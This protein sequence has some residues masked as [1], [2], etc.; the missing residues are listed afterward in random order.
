MYCGVDIGGT[1]VLMALFSEKGTLEK[2]I[3]FPT[4][5]KYPDLLSEL[6]KHSLELVENGD[7]FAAGIAI[8]GRIDRELGT[9]ISF[10]NLGWK[11][12]PIQRDVERILNCP[13]A[14]E[15]DA[16]AGAFSEALCILEDYKKVMYVAIGTGI[17]L[18]YVVDGVI[19]V[20]FGDR[21]GNQLLLPFQGKLQTWE[22]FASGKAIVNRYGKRAED[23]NDQRIWKRISQD[24]ASGIVELMAL[25]DIDAV[26][27]G[28]G[29]GKYFA[30]YGKL[31]NAAVKKYETPVMPA[32]VILP[33]K[34]PDE[35]VVYGGYE[36]A[37]RA[38][39]HPS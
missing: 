24:L 22:S 30:K 12:V 29:V 17:G 20:D 21:G 38:Y 11:N 9:G 10:G 15:N 1:K 18:G 5:K 35:A 13:V 32:P 16:K 39:G 34:H 14:I 27:I 19:D 33:A 26:V 23:I 4:P 2:S 31:L 28:G 3:K 25:V 7:F 6:H 37:K 8:P 36:L